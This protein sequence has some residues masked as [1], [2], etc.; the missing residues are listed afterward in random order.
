MKPYV[1]RLDGLTR[2]DSPTRDGDYSPAFIV[3]KK[4]QLSVRMVAGG[5]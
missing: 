5:K 1:P 2:A 4:T 3:K